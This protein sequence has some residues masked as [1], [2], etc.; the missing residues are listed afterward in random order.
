[1][2]KRKSFLK[3]LIFEAL[4]TIFGA[5]AL[6][7]LILGGLTWLFDPSSRHEIETYSVV[8]FLK[9]I[10]LATLLTPLITFGSWLIL[11][12]SGYGLWIVYKFIRSMFR[13]I[14]MERHPDVREL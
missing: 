12:Y 3:E 8:S 7:T 13:R 2:Q 11:A 4:P 10:G 14:G 1:M 6:L 9:D 5:F